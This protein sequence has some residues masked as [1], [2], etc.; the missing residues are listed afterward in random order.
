MKAVLVILFS[1]LS[2]YGYAQD[3]DSLLVLFWNLENF[4]DYTD[5]G[6]G[7]SDMAFSSMGSR[8]WTKRKFYAKCDNIAKSLLWMEDE[9]GRMPDV[10][11]FAE[12]ENKGVL[13]KLLDN[14][15]LRK[16][17]YGIIHFDSGDSR[18]IDVALL[19]R[20]SLFSFVSY[21][22]KTPVYEGKKMDTRDILNVCLK[23]N[24]GR[25]THFIVNHHP[26][27]YGGS[28]SS[29]VRRDAAMSALKNLCD[30][31]AEFS[32]GPVI[33]MGDF[34]DTPDAGTFGAIENILVNKGID[35]YEKGEGSI[36]YEGRWELID[37]FMVSPEIEEK[38]IMEVCRV[39]FLMTWERKHPGEKPLRTYSGPQYIGGVSDH[40][41]V[42]LWYF[43]DN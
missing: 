18:G 8:R 21:S 4:F 16:C 12:I 17:D 36:R 33:T 22:L 11:G 2:I 26:S 43:R 5:Q 25:D 40:C 42:L 24:A 41:P 1:V 35:L 20:R 6:T 39:P 9:Y 10:V 13:N 19:Y 14:T 34:N 23:D 30:S 32:E 31:L 7:E 15:L 38:T 37:M 27:K 29:D 28:R 3:K